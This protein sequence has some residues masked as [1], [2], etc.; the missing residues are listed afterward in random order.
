MDAAPAR[1]F[2]TKKEFYK[3]FRKKSNAIELWN[4][5]LKN[6]TAVFGLFIMVLIVLMA[7]FAPFIADYNSDAIKP[8]IANRLQGPSASNWLGTDEVGRDILARIVH[9]SRISLFI[10]FSAVGVSLLVGGLFGA[11]AGY[12]GGKTDDIIMRCM[13]VFLCLPDVLLALAIIAAFGQTQTNLIISIG[14]SFAPKFSRVVRA[15]VMSV[16][17]NEY[18]EAARSIGARDTRI[19]MNHVLIN[20]IGPVIVQVTLYVANAI[21]TISALSFI[22]LG[23][24]PPTPEWGNMLASGRTFMRDHMH[25]V[26]APGLAIFF[27]ILA[28]NLLGDGLRDTLDPR[29]KQ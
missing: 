15:A 1:T 4:R 22:G 8:N 2:T 24:N 29:L 6:K 17:D 5:F 28:L 23:I 7:I 11:I 3:Q 21:L 25:L 26:M 20:C 19:I 27:T 9:G 14:L 16:R 13:D 12:Y 10:G 18:I